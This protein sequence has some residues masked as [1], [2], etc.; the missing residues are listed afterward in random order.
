MSTAGNKPL[1]RVDF[2]DFWGELNKADNFFTRLLSQ[3][4]RVEVNDRPDLLIY[5]DKGHTH[6]IYTCRKLF[7]TGES[8]RPDFSQCDYALSQFFVED[9]RNERLPYY[10]IAT[11]GDPAPLL[12]DP[13][14]G[15]RLARE[16][17]KFCAF[18][19]RNGNPRRTRRRLE[20][21]RLLSAYRTVDG[22][23]TVLNNVGGPIPLGTDAK[24]KFLGAYRFNLCFENRAFD[25]YTTEKLPE[26][27]RAGCVPLYWGNPL[28]DRDFNP[29]SFLSLHQF[30]SDAEFVEKV[31]ALD[32][33]EDAR[34]AMLA[35][36]LMPGNRPNEFFRME[37]YVDFL[38]RV[39]ADRAEPV[40]RRKFRLFGRWA[41]V[42][43]HKY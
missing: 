43:R 7:W 14:E 20:M 41:F 39:V 37:R 40:S 10:V 11:G 42:P 16:R 1:L 38:E 26:A 27:Y 13:A 32:L 25:G 30:S 19:A 3:R 24:L 34:A 15:P 21:H 2:T 5:S 28:I 29:K 17:Q 9:P 18:L 8:L 33:N 6:K 22:G 31:K 23:G 35:E 12:R 36:P 4:F